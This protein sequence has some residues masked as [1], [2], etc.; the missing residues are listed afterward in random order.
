M[1]ALRLERRRSAAAEP[2]PPNSWLHFDFPA[3]LPSACA[4]ASKQIAL[5]M[6]S[7]EPARGGK[8]ARH[9][10]LVGGA[11]SM[12]RGVKVSERSGPSEIGS[13]LVLDD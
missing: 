8:T 2:G 1:A 13:H 4:Q 7:H 9:T 3:E 6:N 10:R 12:G 11:E 5:T